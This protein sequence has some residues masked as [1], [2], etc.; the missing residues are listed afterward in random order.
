MESIAATLTNVRLAQITAR[1]M[2]SVLTR[3]DRSCVNARL[4]L[5]AM[6][7]RVATKTNAKA[8]T[9]AL[10]MRFA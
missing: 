9:V 5:P 1:T 2:R 8:K 4:D 6:G 7:E 10:K 3:K